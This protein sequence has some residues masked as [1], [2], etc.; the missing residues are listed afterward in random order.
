[1]FMSFRFSDAEKDYNTS[2][3]KL[4]VIRCLE[5]CRW[6]VVGSKHPI[7]LYTNHSALVWILKGYHAAG[8][9]VRWQY[10]LSEYNLEIHYIPR[11]MNAVA[12]EPSTLA[13]PKCPGPDNDSFP[14][15]SMVMEE[16]NF[17]ASIDRKAW[18]S[19]F[20]CD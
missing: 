14:L 4:A 20:D 19:Y 2:E 1:M 5:E 15:T 16:I 3:R 6:L 11:Q 17:Q 18:K 10:R 8:R 12:D 13:E 9:I 7:C